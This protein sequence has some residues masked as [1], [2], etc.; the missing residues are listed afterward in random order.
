MNFTLSG[1]LLSLSH[2]VSP[3][4]PVTPDSP[5]GIMGGGVCAHPLPMGGC[6]CEG[7]VLV[8]PTSGRELW[9]MNCA[10]LRPGGGGREGG[11]G[12]CVE[13]AE[14]GGACCWDWLWLACER[15]CVRNIRQFSNHWTSTSQATFC[16]S[17]ISSGTVSNKMG[18]EK[19]GSP[20]QLNTRELESSQ[21]N[22]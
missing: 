5:T 17:V 18:L 2:P 12:I 3:E 15:I 21:V 1:S 13:D 11:G 20:N 19:Q 22:P 10:G 8:Q 9:R 14:D 6:R 7:G 16:S 4:L